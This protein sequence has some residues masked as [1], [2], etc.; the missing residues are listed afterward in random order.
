MAAY[1][2]L[3]YFSLTCSVIAATHWRWIPPAEPPSSSPPRIRAAFEGAGCSSV[4]RAPTIHGTKMNR[5]PAAGLRRD[6]SAACPDFCRSSRYRFIHVPGARRRTVHLRQKP[7]DPVEDTNDTLGSRPFARHHRPRGEG[8]RY[9]RRA[10][11]CDRLGGEQLQGRGDRA[12]PARSPDAD[13]ARDRAGHGLR[14]GLERSLQSRVNIKYGMKY[15]AGAE[16]ACG[17]RFA[18]RSSSTMPGTIPSA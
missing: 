4:R 5:L 17:E 12:G 10:R 9:P 13:Q 15:L 11:P 3:E 1:G 16:T 18:A 14:G 2:R 7:T 6:A 8:Q